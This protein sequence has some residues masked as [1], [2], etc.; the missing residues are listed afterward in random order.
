MNHRVLR[1]VDWLISVPSQPYFANRPEFAF[2][3]NL[4]GAEMRAAEQ[5]LTHRIAMLGM[6]QDV[7]SAFIVISSNRSI[8][9]LN[10]D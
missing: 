8:C 5:E 6:Q 4:T 1:F 3:A 10:D 7:L 9:G 2:Y